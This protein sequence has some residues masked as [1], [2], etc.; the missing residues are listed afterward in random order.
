MSDSSN[1]SPEKGEPKIE[2]KD[3]FA[4]HE[5]PEKTELGPEN[6]DFEQPQPIIKSGEPEKPSIFSTTER[7]AF[8]RAGEE[9]SD[10][11]G[12]GS[13]SAPAPPPQKKTEA[14]KVSVQ[15]GQKPPPPVEDKT[16]EK[17]TAA[18]EE[19]ETEG[20]KEGAPS[21]FEKNPYVKQSLMK[22]NLWKSDDLRKTTKLGRSERGAL[23]K[24]FF[25]DRH[26]V[27]KEDVQKAIRSIESGKVKPP[28]SLGSG[29]IG[30]TRATNVLR[31]FLGEKHKKVY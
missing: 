11:S 27:R 14:A 12:E 23:A 2:Q 17:K 20:K 10:R 18:K 29:R 6:P 31:G 21:I 3:Q 7:A 24:E 1:L 25:P 13:F 15:K 26:F 8:P 19:K 5:R 28:A 9:G 22:F 16:K 30:R 4:S